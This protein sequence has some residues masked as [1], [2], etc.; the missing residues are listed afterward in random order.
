[1]PSIA[2]LR[3]LY[4]DARDASD[5]EILS[6]V[7][8]RTGMDLASTAQALGYET[9][10]GGV[11]KQ[12]LSSS[13]DRY[14]AGLYGVGEEIAS[15]LGAEGA[16]N[17]MAQQ[18][19]D[20]E[21]RADIASSRARSL[22]A[23]DRW[24]DVH[25]VGDF[26]SYAKGL[27][28]QSLPYAGEAL[29]GGML[30]RGAMA[31]TRAALAGAKTVEEA[32]AAKK[33]L[34]LG[35]QAGA[36]AASYPSAV[37]DVLSNQREQ[38]GETRGG[39]AAAL[40]VPYAA[41][42]AVG[43]ESALARGTTFKNTVNILDRGTG[44]SG[45]AA[46]MA[47]TG[48]GV[49]LKEGASETGQE[50]LNQVG[51]MSVD[52]NEE[53]LSAAAQERFKE[54][55]IGGATLGGVAGAVG[56]GWRRSSAGGNDVSQAIGDKAATQP[57]ITTT[58]F[59]ARDVSSDLMAGLAGRGANPL[60]GRSNMIGGELPVLPPQTA[61]AVT[62]GTTDVAQ[63]S[64]G[65]TQAQFAEQQRQQ[66]DAA[67]QA[68][69]DKTFQTLGAQY[70]PDNT[71]QLTIFG[72]T[73][74]DD[75]KI[76][77]FGNTLA[78]K[79]NAL[80]D[81]AHAVADAIAQ[82]N[83]LTGGKVIKVS[84]NAANPVGAANTVMKA[85]ASTA[86]KF[87]IGHVQ[88][89]QQA[90]KILETLSQTEKGNKL[91][92]LNAIHYALTGED[93][94]G[95]L[96]AQ[97]AK[98]TKA[99]KGAKNAKLSVQTTAG[100]G[101]V[102]VEGGTTEAISGGDGSVRPTQIQPVGAASVGEGPL[103]LQVG[104]PP[105]SGVRTSAGDVSNVGS[106]EAAPQVIADQVDSLLNR[107]VNG[108]F[109][110][111]VVTAEERALTRKLVGK[112]ISDGLA[113][114]K[115][116]TE[117][118]D[119]VNS[120]TGNNLSS[121]AINDLDRL[122]TDIRKG[123][124]NE[125]IQTTKPRAKLG[126][127]V[128]VKAT[129][130]QG[131]PSVQPTPAPAPKATQRQETKLSQAE[132]LW[133]DMDATDT[134]YASLTPAL[135][136]AW[137]KAIETNNA[138]GAIQEQIADQA[139][140]RAQETKADRLIAGI[141]QTVIR[142]YGRL[143]EV[144]AQKKREFFQAFWGGAKLD[145]LS[146]IAEDM[147]ITKDQALKWHAELPKFL[148]KNGDKI[149]AAAA[150]VA[151]S[152][153]MTMRE[154]EQLLEGIEA[155]RQKK[156]TTVAQVTGEE[157]ESGQGTS[158]TEEPVE[159]DTTG[160]DEFSVDE[161]TSEGGRDEGP[162]VETE[163][164]AAADTNIRTRK[165]MSIQERFNAVET[166]NA[167]ILRTMEA[168]EKA[169][170]DLEKGKTPKVS[171]EELE[172]RL[173][174]EMD[175]AKQLYTKNL[176]KGE[177][178]GDLEQTKEEIAKDEK[179]LATEAAKKLQEKTN[180]VQEPSAKEVPVRK[181]AGG[182]K[183]LGE[184]NAEGGQAATEGEA[185]AEAQEIILYHG[186]SATGVT[187]GTLDMP[188]S[189]GQLGIHFG[190]QTTAKT[191]A[192]ENVVEAKIRLGNAL[193]MPD[194][195]I[196]SAATVVPEL[197]KRFSDAKS[198]ALL[199]QFETDN[200]KLMVRGATFD[201]VKLRKLLISLGVDT[202]VYTN[203]FENAGTDSYIVLDKNNI[204][205]T[206]TQK[207]KTD[208]E[209][210]ADAWDAVVK[211][212]PGAPMFMSLTPEEK[213]TFIE[214]G[215]ENW[216]R[217]DIVAEL[218]KLN[219][220]QPMQGATTEEERKDAEA[221]AAETGG[222]V[223]W[224]DGPWAL[225]RG[226][227]VLSGQPV[228]VPANGAS[229]WRKDIEGLPETVPIPADMR[230]KLIA[231]KKEAEAAD[232]AQ[233]AANPFIK[234]EGNGLALSS[235]VDRRLG[236]V[237]AGWKNLLNIKANV[238]ITTLEDAR[239]D[240]DKFTG[241]HR[242]IGSAGLDANEAGSMR[243]MGTDYYIAFTK[244]TSYLKMLE[245]LAH[246]LGHLHQDE[247]FRNAP[248]D[249][250]LAI[251]EEHEK[252]VKA[253]KGKT[254]REFVTAL[255]ARTTGRA[256]KL[257]AGAQASELTEYWRSFSE[258]YA[259][260]VSKW[261][262]SSEKP[263][264]VVETF[265][266]K[267]G[268]ALKK[269][270]Y[271]LKGKQY[272]PTETMKQFLDSVAD[273]KLIIA[274][275]NADTGTESRAILAGIRSMNN[276]KGEA[277][278][279]LKGRFATAKIMEAAGDS[280][281]A[282]WAQT[283]WYK[284]VEGKWRYEILDTDT[285]F[286]NGYDWEDFPPDRPM[287]LDDV[288]DH[289]ELFKAIPSLLD[290]TV[291]K[292]SNMPAGSGSYNARTDEIHVGDI[293][294][295]GTE[296]DNTLA[297]QTLLHEVQH[298]VQEREGFA[299]GGNLE[300]VDP[301]DYASFEKLVWQRPVSTNQRAIMLLE[302][303]IP[304]HQEV[305]EAEIKA[306]E[307]YANMGD[308][309]TMAQVMRYNHLEETAQRLRDS[310]E[311]AVE[312]AWAP[313]GGK[314]FASS[315]RQELYEMIGGE[316]EANVVMRRQGKSAEE[317]AKKL[318]Q[319]IKPLNQLLYSGSE[320][321]A[322]KIA[323]LPKPLQVPT[324][325]VV[326]TLL[327][328]GKATM[329]N[330]NEDVKHILLAAGI[331]EDVV[332]GA[333]K[334]MPSAQDYLNSQYERQGTRIEHEQRIQR[335]E[336][337]FEKLP[338]ELQG[339]GRGSV[340][341]FIFD[342]TSDSKWGYV[343][344]YN[345]NIKPDDEMARRFD[346]MPAAAQS[347]IKM[348]FDHGYQ[349]L[350]LKQ[351]AVKAAADKEFSQREADANGDQ[352]ILNE[353]AAER[354]AWE[355]KFDRLM[356]IKND[357][358]YAYLG[359]YGDYVAVAKSETYVDAEKLSAQGDLDATKWLEQNQS[360]ANHYIVEFAE[361]MAEAQSKA[362]QWKATGQYQQVYG[363]EKE[364]SEAF[365]G[366][367]DLFMGITRLRNMIT[368]RIKSG[369]LTIADQ[370]TLDALHKTVSDLYLATVSE[371][372][373]HRTA[374]QRKNISGADKDMMRNLATRGRADAHFLASL[375]HNDN[376][377]DAISNMRDEAKGDPTNAR[378][379]LNELL[380]RY[381]N[382][383]N[384]KTPAPWS[385][386]MT[387]LGHT[388]FL[389][390]N[391]AFYLQQMTQT[392]VLSLPYMAGRLGYHRSLRSINAA[393]KDVVSL[394]K[395]TNVNEHLDFSKAPADVRDMLL[396]LVR[397]GKID[398]GID[399][400]AV[401][402]A[403]ERTLTSSVMRKLNGVNNRIE[404]VNRATAAV[405]AYRGYLQRFGANNTEAAT[406][407]AA[408]TVSNTHGSYDGFN[409][410][411]ILN[412]NVGRVVGQFKRFQIIQLSMLGKLIKN[413]FKGASA[414]ERMVA[415]RSLAFITSH[416]AVLGGALG[417]PFV[418]QVANLLNHMFGDDDEPKDLEYQLRQA[419][420]DPA[421]ANLL[422]RG[423]PAFLGLESLG[424]KLSMENVASIL[425]FTDVDLTSRSGAEKMLVGLMGPSAALSLKA[426]DALGLVGKG[427]YYKGL[428]QALPSGFASAMKAYRF[429]TEGITLRNGDVVLSPE[430]V[431]MVDAAFQAVGL[432]TNTITQRQYRQN[433]EKEFDKFFQTKATEIKGDYVAASR[434]GDGPA[435][436]EARQMW[437]ELQ[438]SRAKHGYTKQPMSELFKAVMA[439]RKREASTV[440]GV[441][442]TKANK[443]FVKNII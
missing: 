146:E 22:G 144:S 90:A 31:G 290:I 304:Q 432:P 243:K 319:S 190:D 170:A 61:P 25:G 9:T 2:Q 271:S 392:Y 245:T 348:V 192:A 72:G 110:P 14:Q 264:G 338:T 302:P 30:A 94:T 70:T 17:W 294:L 178:G 107:L 181:R 39:V 337:A 42:N 151:E 397:M 309:P 364:V 251:R 396:K 320:T 289:P 229:R 384:Y 205:A 213:E 403:N 235:G 143:D 394:V 74:F 161:L 241:P 197:K 45:A 147:G 83:E 279:A 416:M 210:A 204:T 433:V 193:R 342:S 314:R 387:R 311:K 109:G 99:N 316:A 130:K 168:I 5:A 103:G 136:Q 66:Q 156:E 201:D 399:A 293:S 393:Y 58:D 177:F 18:R 207:V 270:Y 253:N 436:T 173:A 365:V 57:D 52:S 68:V 91:E 171:V 346:A 78:A 26:G 186:T 370:E 141:L 23:V 287:M 175:Y 376:I 46:R 128:R 27:A 297:L 350:R 50:M 64:T 124:T 155:K 421:L 182:G 81:T 308:N 104:Q 8:Q 391:P 274:P 118:L 443:Q 62:G 328:S 96:E 212:I 138:T 112:I 85:L 232:A 283:G 386:M 355:S 36:V 327:N 379:Y 84:L 237:V 354:T 149:I 255:R 248:D 167:R 56:G 180:A 108:G 291:T 366:G 116:N 426:A 135:K 179:R 7:S 53:F 371:A 77:V 137:D 206:P 329:I 344:A 258:W 336:E 176:A 307:Y 369:E 275:T 406:K 34:D 65:I 267:L 4:P 299:K 227:S 359:R 221:H 286:V 21:L 375:K 224:Q 340:N 405:A 86:D 169:K 216:T 75:A 439:A 228:Y 202:I 67:N 37:G 343:P 429:A 425:P 385:Q 148:E 226:Y 6:W 12:Q 238:Y 185:K 288:L 44:I 187:A 242:A 317:L 301:Y 261:A 174:V 222:S 412:S 358:P 326:D 313:L 125:E 43:V 122:I 321:V 73:L 263:V 234:F 29:A 55:F 424:K 82:A 435:M 413:A 219:A 427:E 380:K 152:Q 367:S 351:K 332:N 331:T 296:E 208:A 111:D 101:T 282:I 259:D 119:K 217:A 198:R 333:T 189:T 79:F 114:G 35:S 47:A 223:V 349:S 195:D 215:E 266:A 407:F 150:Y 13:I 24:E 422:T 300:A 378:P 127:P 278:D 418:S 98:A 230:A 166:N 440:E 134:P 244:G 89:V 214:Y 410:P 106:S 211:D 273:R 196:W 382:D 92:Q 438:E 363:A 409:T 209:K 154:L 315:V 145:S 200:P 76:N 87:Q 225:I 249:V 423:V 306:A 157:E 415:R 310:L 357:M 277:K 414:E 184:G 295:Q 38:S 262:T 48:T 164:E 268:A 40:A 398:I 100:M 260:Q 352:E 160:E 97:Q 285:K 389:S 231:A 153:G 80:P 95:F 318:P 325:T 276:M 377:T 129:G 390:F 123:T 247:A 218:K 1:M 113:A 71:G 88:T 256:T 105:A 188:S 20:N 33:A 431:S 402:Y 54:S 162:E 373:A 117:I 339:T 280:P 252:F 93:T 381:A 158:A 419:I 139:N 246:E 191:R 236:G 59:Q 404:A 312:N 292:D 442:T 3:E 362:E 360:D 281:A 140:D 341:E 383:I 417:V 265:F 430:E 400:D 240:K 102:P 347:V 284:G 356:N 183:S 233:H 353:I 11:T 330:R 10:K 428:E 69:R 165:S 401:V 322:R 126:V 60:A 257:P 163:A 220:A 372:S 16:S 133:N 32:A 15:G 159:S 254:A 441:E 172:A 334:F 408:E 41:L 298:A 49:A 323:S 368:R 324:K 199:A 374:M 131:A 51:R 335:I 388:W 361:T 434:E 250:Q 272:L 420:G 115:T 28:I 121:A 142:P 132:E 63:A 19:K 194:L 395:D 437:Q 305:R 411:R 269:F 303:F 203:K 345:P 120:T 239:A